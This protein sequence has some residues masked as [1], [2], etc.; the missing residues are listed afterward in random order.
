METAAGIEDGTLASVGVPVLAS[1]FGFVA[2]TRMM[3]R[4]DP[5]ASEGA[6]MALA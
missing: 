1:L 6:E 4:P 2:S 3:R 5:V